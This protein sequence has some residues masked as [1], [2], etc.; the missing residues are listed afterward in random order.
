MMMMMIDTIGWISCGC[1]CGW[2]DLRRIGRCADG[3]FTVVVDH[4][5]WVL[6]YGDGG[7]GLL[8]LFCRIRGLLVVFWI[9]IVGYDVVFDSR[10]GRGDFGGVVSI[11]Q[12]V[13]RL[14][15]GRFNGR[16]EW[17]F[18][19]FLTAARRLLLLLL[20]RRGRGLC[21]GFTVCRFGLVCL[22]VGKVGKRGCYDCLWLV[23]G[24]RF[25]RLAVGLVIYR[26]KVMV[27]VEQVLYELRAGE[28]R[29]AARVGRRSGRDRVVIVMFGRV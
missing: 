2:I 14:L 28:K 23:R 27:R 25:V 5:S 6:G 24:R 12:V 16:D 26:L 8:G 13:E 29:R 7:W 1:G 11:G 20:W 3:E 19:R 17:S 18:S 4:W 10:K 15:N 21:A 22:W 9:V